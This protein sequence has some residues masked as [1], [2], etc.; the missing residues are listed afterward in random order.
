MG[1]FKSVDSMIT[2][3]S[4]LHSNKY[5]YELITDYKPGKPIDIICKIHGVFK[6][7][8]H[9]HKAGYGCLQCQLEDKTIFDTLYKPKTDKFISKFIEVHGD[10]YDY[11]KTIV[12]ST[13]FVTIICKEHGEFK[14]RI[15]D[16]LNGFNCPICGA[17]S[18]RSKLMQTINDVI[19]KA[20]SIH[21]FKYD[22]SKSIYDGNSVKIEII[23]HKHG[24]FWQTPDNHINRKSGCPHCKSKWKSQDLW[25][26]DIGLPRGSNYR[27]VRLANDGITNGRKKFVVDGFDPLT[28][29]IYEFLGDH[30]HGNPKLFNGSNLHCYSKTKLE[31]LHMRTLIKFEYLFNRGFTIIYIWENQFNLGNISGHTYNPNDELIY[32]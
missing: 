7:T 8:S 17:N 21:N 20:N 11:S 19:L 10:R 18:M 2:S 22:Y 29:T 30:H 28:N 15:F 12:D 26:D 25:L 3:I 16:H 1:K 31:V 5:S 27:Q 9:A 13:H 14:Q 23:C 4:K 6:L 32:I 24:S